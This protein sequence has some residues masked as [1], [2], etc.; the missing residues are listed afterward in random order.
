MQNKDKVAKAIEALPREVL[1]RF[2]DNVTAILYW[3]NGVW[4]L[5]K[6]WEPGFLDTVAEQL[7]PAV[8]EGLALEAPEAT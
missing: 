1:E 3:E 8:C 5:E 7:P 2:V 6:D 4:N